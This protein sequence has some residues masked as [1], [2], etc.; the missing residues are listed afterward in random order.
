MK[1]TLFLIPL[2]AIFLIGCNNQA[3]EYSKFTDVE[4]TNKTL[5]KKEYFNKTLGGLLGQFAGFL[6]GYEFV[7]D[8]PNPYVGMP[9]EWFEFLNGPYAGNYD[10]YFPGDYATQGIYDR[11]KL[12]EETNMYEVW[13]DDDYHI[14]IFNQ[15]I[16][17]EFGSSSYGIKEAWKKYLVSDWGGGSDAMNLINRYDLL[18]PFT[19]TIEGG[20]RYGWCTEGYIENETLG[21]N[22]PG[23]PNVA[24]ELIDKFA[25]NVAYGDS[26]IWAKFYGTMYSLAYFEDDVKTIMEEAKEVL[27]LNSRPREI[28]D[29]CIEL[30]NEHPND[31]ELVAKEIALWR[32]PIYRIDNIQTDPSINGA[33]AI[34]SWLYGN[35]DYMDTCMYS[36]MFGYDGDCTSAICTGLMGV[37]NGFKETNEEYDKLTSLIYYNGEGVYFNDRDSGFP[38]SIKS[39]EYFTRIKIDDIVKL[40]QKNFE[41]I[42]VANGG[43]I[44]GDN[45]IIPTTTVYKDHS[46]LFK[47]YNA[48][49]RNTDGFSYS[50]NDLKVFTEGTNTN[51]HT[52]Y[53]GF[54]LTNSGN[55]E[56]YHKFSDL[57]KGSYYR[58]S[59][60]VKTSS[61]TE[62]ELFARTGDDVQIITFASQEDL[63]NKTFI[64]KAN[65][66]DVE[67]GFKFTDDSNNGDK[68]YFDDFMLEEIDYKL[69]SNISDQDLKISSNTYTKNIK[70]PS[71][72]EL[73]E[74]IIIKIQYK[75]YSDTTIASLNRNGNLFG[76]FVFSNTSL[77]ST[78]DGYDYAYIPY[79]FE[80]DSDI[81][82][83]NFEGKRIYIGSIGI[84]DESQFMFR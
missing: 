24:S 64:F 40:Y 18:A 19:G 3:S 10:H 14:D 31:Y 69:I 22:A 50:N 43:K 66:N 44:E 79:V 6:S 12:N 49:E 74:E 81:I 38:P 73:N 29:K 8:G 71:E 51:S 35:N 83:I 52:G 62:I 67:V 75:N 65:S 37:I 72:V 26:I 61:D 82:N 17:D 36:S 55:S 60:Y 59:T 7:W 11:H 47:N 76:S 58:L 57:H 16:L 53:A 4:I 25:S 68:L 46:H 45:Y 42:L 34:M 23:M 30:Y 1:R 9:L 5:S 32:E 41:E 78:S 20:N 28:Y 77:K 39:D 70:K 27:P 2:S 54:E 15:T 21:M 13:S 84:L 33:Y 80:K 48:E 56:A 63:I